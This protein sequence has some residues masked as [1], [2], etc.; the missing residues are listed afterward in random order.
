MFE[1]SYSQ[2]SR[3]NSFFL[4]V[5]ALISLVQSFVL[6]LYRLRFVLSF[7][8]VFPLMGKAESGGNPVHEMRHP[9]QGATG[10]WVMPGLVFKWFPLWKFSLFDIP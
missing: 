4:L 6:A 3:L 2:A 9:A 8:F 10:G 5:S 7:L 1:V